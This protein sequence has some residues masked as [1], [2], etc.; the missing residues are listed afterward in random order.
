MS[1]TK[2]ATVRVLEQPSV[3]SDVSPS[4]DYATIVLRRFATLASGQDTSNTVVTTLKM[5]VQKAIQEADDK[6]N[7]HALRSDIAEIHTFRPNRRDLK[8]ELSRS[9]YRSNEIMI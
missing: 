5:K 1:Q 8:E 7:G 4:E 2:R 9:D 3:V 6:V